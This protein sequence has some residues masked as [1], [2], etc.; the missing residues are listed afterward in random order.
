MQTICHPYHVKALLVHTLNS[1]A[2]LD[3]DIAPTEAMAPRASVHS[4]RYTE[5]FYPNL[6]CAGALSYFIRGQVE[7]K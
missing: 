2:L 5:G 6:R 1:I 3:D 4:I 7:L